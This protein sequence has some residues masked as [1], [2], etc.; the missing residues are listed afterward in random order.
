MEFRVHATDILP[1]PG[2]RFGHRN[3]LVR[4]VVF[5]NRA[6]HMSPEMIRIHFESPPPFSQHSKVEISDSPNPQT[7]GLLRTQHRVPS[8]PSKFFSCVCYTPNEI[9]SDSINLLN[10]T[11]RSQK[12]RQVVRRNTP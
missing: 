7:T 1:T 5:V 6:N 8:D 12:Q 11:L 2:D 4:S 10:Y 9:P 3:K